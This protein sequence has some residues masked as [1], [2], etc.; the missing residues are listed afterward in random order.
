L[1]HNHTCSKF[2]HKIETALGNL[3]MPYE[4]EQVHDILDKHYYKEFRRLNCSDFD[5]NRLKFITTNIANILEFSIT[6]NNK[7]NGRNI[8]SYSDDVSFSTVEKSDIRTTISNID[9]I[10]RK[11]SELYKNGRNSVFPLYVSHR[12]L[13]DIVTP[14]I[15]ETLCLDEIGT[16]YEHVVPLKFTLPAASMIQ[17]P[18]SSIIKPTTA[19]GMADVPAIFNRLTRALIGPICY[20]SQH[21]D[22]RLH[23]TATDDWPRPFSRYIE[24][25]VSRDT[26]GEEI[27]IYETLTGKPI[28]AAKFS[29]ADH[30]DTMKEA[31]AYAPLADFFE[32]M[33]C[34]LQKHHPVLWSNLQDSA[35]KIANYPAGIVADP[36]RF[37]PDQRKKLRKLIL[38]QAELGPFTS[39]QRPAVES[40]V[41]RDRLTLTVRHPSS[42]KPLFRVNLGPEERKR[43]IHFASGSMH[44]SGRQCVED[45]KNRLIKQDI[46]NHLINMG[47]FTAARRNKNKIEWLTYQFSCAKA[48]N[49]FEQT[50]LFIPI[51]LDCIKYLYPGFT[52]TLRS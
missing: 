22:N 42:D 9:N 40:P 23:R 8:A 7:Y 38:D 20:V 44:E 49:H 10:I 36:D 43:E 12:F 4:P 34:W 24:P 3:I 37:T 35:Q 18:A 16:V 2:I 17:D 13:L 21:E 5:N 26:P 47:H 15:E 31:P 28:N 39:K 48:G 14:D 50:K 11:T 52:E 1:R 25:G 41:N 27:I 19:E 46:S 29:W 33:P 30:L 32:T 51:L 45:I 6:L